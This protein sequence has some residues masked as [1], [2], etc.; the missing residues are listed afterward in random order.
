MSVGLAME[1]SGVALVATHLMV[2]WQRA[3][4]QEYFVLSADANNRLFCTENEE[5]L[6]VKAC[7][8]TMNISSRRGI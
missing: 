4:L 5:D 3:R 6:M 7:G 8:N 2:E 1:V